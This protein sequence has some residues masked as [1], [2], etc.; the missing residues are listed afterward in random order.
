MTL[1]LG[2]LAPYASSS[3]FAACWACS[4]SSAFQISVNAAFASGWVVLGCW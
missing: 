4:S 2:H 1:A 3:A